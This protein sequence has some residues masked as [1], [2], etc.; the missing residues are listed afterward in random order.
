MQYYLVAPVVIVRKNVQAFTY[1]SEAQ[2]AIG[3]IVTISVGKKILT[4]IVIEQTKRPDFATKSI[5][6]ILTNPGLP[7]ALVQLAHWM[8]EY[9]VTP[10]PIVLQTILPSGLNKKR[11]QLTF[12]QPGVQRQNKKIILNGQQSAALQAIAATPSGTILLH[13]VT[14]SGKTQVYIEAAKHQSEQGRSSIILVPEISLTPQLVAEFAN[15]YKNIIVTHSTMTEAQRHQVWLQTLMAAEPIIVIGPRSALFMP[16]NNLGLIVVDECHEPSYKQEQ[17]PRYSALRVASKLASM[18]PQAKVVFGSA[19]PA[20]SDYY[21]SETTHNPLI[22]LTK[23]AV[24]VTQP[25]TQLIDCK[26]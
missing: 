6:E 10:L 24:D 20:V 12:T 19:T 14:G 2:L 3:A 9:Y 15:Y 23:T 7:Q 26:N 21:L 8:S 1:H 25:L 16:I 22:K 4:G 17:S 18:H 5:A 11:R 13:G